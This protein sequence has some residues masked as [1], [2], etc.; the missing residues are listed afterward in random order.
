MQCWELFPEDFRRAIAS[1]LYTAPRAASPQPRPQLQ[2]PPS[3]PSD[4][5]YQHFSSLNLPPSKVALLNKVTKGI[6]NALHLREEE[7]L[8]LWP[9]EDVS[10]SKK[11]KELAVSVCGASTECAG[12]LRLL[13]FA[14][15][16][17]HIETTVKRRNGQRKRSAAF[18]EIA[19]Q[20]NIGVQKVRDACKRKRNY[21]TFAE[22]WGL[23][24][25]L[26]LGANMSE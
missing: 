23:G 26:E 4:D 12:P 22:K 9:L 10:T 25:L 18:E 17:D 8:Q 1:S 11:T 3:Q 6:V 15:S 16:V 2:P 5:L 13:F 21:I 7:Y 14:H 20:C 19:N 24:C